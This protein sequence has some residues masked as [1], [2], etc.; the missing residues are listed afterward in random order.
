MAFYFLLLGPRPRAA[1]WFLAG[2]ALIGTIFSIGQQSRGV[3]FLSQD[4]ASAAIAWFVL[5]ALWRLLLASESRQEP[6]R[7]P[8]VAS[9]SANPAT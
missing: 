5:L 1:R 7:Q 3:H 2:A 9:S 4:L 6:G 8:S